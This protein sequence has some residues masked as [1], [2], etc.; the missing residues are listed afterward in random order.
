MLFQVNGVM[1][2]DSTRSPPK[3]FSKDFLSVE[4]SGPDE[5]HLS[6]IDVPGIFKKTTEGVTTK[7][8]M[9]M[10]NGMVESYVSNPRS[11]I[12]AVVPANVDIA[13]QEIL[14][15]AE[16]HDPEGQ[17]TLGVL[18]KPDLVDEGAERDILDLL[19]GQKHKLALGWCVLRNLGQKE[20]GEDRERHT[21]E[22][23]FFTTRVP[24]NQVEK[25]R[26]G[27]EALRVRLGRIL[28]QH[29]RR[30]FPKVRMNR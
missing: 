27:V 22:S 8:D 21:T 9:A 4:V 12:L 25:T 6:V 18:T 11:I 29:T 26:A 3:T 20:S 10:V 7:A 14:D 23:A 1:G 28:V 16:H 13:T 24:W 17:R 30:E 19:K 15:I 2:I 5:E